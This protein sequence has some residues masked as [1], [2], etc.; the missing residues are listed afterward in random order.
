MA[1][2]RNSPGETGRAR[3]GLL[4]LAPVAWLSRQLEAE[5]AGWFHWQP[6]AFG[7][8]CAI[9]FALPVE[10]GP[11]IIASLALVAVAL[12]ALRPKGTLPS[13]LAALLALAALGL[14]AAKLRTEWVRAPVLEERLGPVDVRGFIELVEPRP[15]GGERLTLLPSTIQKLPPDKL[16]QR[17]RVSTRENAGTL[18]PGDYVEFTAR[19]FPPPRSAVPGGY[20]FA[21]Y[22]WFRGIGAVGYATTPPALAGYDEPVTA[23]MSLENWL[24]GLRKAIGDRITAAL[25]GE[26]A[27]SPPL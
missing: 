10:P 23:L 25:P 18:K 19:L 21:R 3:H 16:P 1:L 15:D 27:P 7:T 22:A 8:G 11:W 6:V 2:L 20:D 26:T 5:R 4:T 9:Y 24:A 14:V 17:I 12:I 13:A